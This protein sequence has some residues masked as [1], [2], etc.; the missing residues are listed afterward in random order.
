MR[1][2]F[3]LALPLLAG[4]GP[5]LPDTRQAELGVDR[6]KAVQAETQKRVD[7]MEKTLAG[8]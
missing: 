6:S 4:C 8:K 5:K 1:F 7:D 2:L 3:L